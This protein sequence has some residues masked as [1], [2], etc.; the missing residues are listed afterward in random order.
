MPGT[1]TIARKL[2][3]R[4]RGLSSVFPFPPITP[5]VCLRALG[6]APLRLDLLVSTAVAGSTGFWLN[7][8]RDGRA[9]EREDALFYHSGQ[10]TELGVFV[11]KRRFELNREGGDK[12][13]RE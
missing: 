5:P 2:D 11:D 9:F 8:C 6:K 3:L 13:I 12:S 7:R 1:R 10:G 4:G